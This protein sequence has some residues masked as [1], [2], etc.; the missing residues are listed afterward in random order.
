MK[1][2]SSKLYD[3]VIETHHLK[4]GTFYFFDNLVIA[5]INEG[6]HIDLESSKDFFIIANEFFANGKPF[7]YIS[8]RINHFSVSP[9]DFA[10]YSL[11]LEN[12]KAFCAITYNNYYDKMNVEIERR[13]YTKPFYC[14]NEIEDAVNWS[15]NIINGGNKA[16][17]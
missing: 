5:E 7:G 11:K 9:I 17:A 12:I 8:N 13:F 1:L 15:N 6:M 2:I 14:T 16:I 3:S 4:I 10:N